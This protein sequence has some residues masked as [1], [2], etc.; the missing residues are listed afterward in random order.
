[1]KEN[2][3]NSIQS[4]KVFIF[5]E[6]FLNYFP[7]ALTFLMPVFFLTTFTEF[8]EYSKFVL[9][10]GGTLLLTVFL[11]L[12]LLLSSKV[13]ITKSNLDAPIWIYLATFTLS[14]FL[15]VNQID[16]IFGTQTK[17]VPSLIALATFILYFYVI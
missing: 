17:W 12:K 13:Y 7:V 1:M 5:V 2:K 4:N 15:S 10:L 6:F 9:F 8:Y 3:L 16:S 14:T 11:I